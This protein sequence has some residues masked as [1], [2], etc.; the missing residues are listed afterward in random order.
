MIYGIIALMVAA[1]MGYR[2]YYMGFKKQWPLL[3][4]VLVS[5]YVAVMGTR[6]ICELAPGIEQYQYYKAPM[7]VIFGII[8]FLL[9]TLIAHLFAKEDYID[10][11][12]HALENYAGAVLGFFTGFA[13]TGFV[14]FSIYLFAAKVQ[15][16]PEFVENDIAGPSAKAVSKSCKIVSTFSLQSTRSDQEIEKTIVWLSGKEVLPSANQK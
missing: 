1:F 13:M 5:I 7:V 6:A 4:N 3:F 8:V 11:I 10:S 2:G 15:A 9:L 12:P 14:V 16:M